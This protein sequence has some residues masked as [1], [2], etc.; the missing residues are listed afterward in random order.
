MKAIIVDIDGTMANFDHRKDLLYR[1]VATGDYEESQKASRQDP[2][3]V[4]CQNLVKIYHDAGYQIIFLTAR[5]EKYYTETAQWLNSHLED[6]IVYVLLMRPLNDDRPDDVV[7]ED[8]YRRDIALQFN[9]EFALDD[10]DSVVDM[11]RNRIGIP[12][13]QVQKGQY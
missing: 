1:D 11:W 13:L 12:C 6:Y 4:W 2:P 3:Y 5:N 7:K 10:R 9:V 8:I